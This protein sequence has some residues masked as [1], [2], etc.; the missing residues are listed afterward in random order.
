MCKVVLF[1]LTN[2]KRIRYNFVKGG[3]IVLAKE[4]ISE[5]TFWNLVDDFEN[6][7]SF[8]PKVRKSFKHYILEM[9]NKIED[10]EDEINHIQEEFDKY[11]R[12]IENDYDPEIEI[13]QIHGK[14]ISY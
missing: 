4:I 6:I 3:K 9:R 8:T 11:K 14:G 2:E 13:P 5:K 7:E 10:L 12:Q 1:V